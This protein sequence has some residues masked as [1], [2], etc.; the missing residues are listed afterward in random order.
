MKAD[1]DRIT[2]SSLSIACVS[3][4]HAR[5][6]ETPECDILI[7]SGDLT[8]HSSDKELEWFKNWIKAR[9]ARYKVFIAGNHDKKFQTHPYGSKDYV[10]ELCAKGDV[11]Y[12]EDTGCTVEGLT[13]WGSPWTPKFGESAFNL[14]GERDALE[15]WKKVPEGIDVLITHG[16]P[17]GILDTLANGKHVGDT[18]LIKAVARVKP[19]L[20]V[21]G[22]VHTGYGRTE[23]DGIVYVNAALCNEQ[24]WDY[25]VVNKPI[26]VDVKELRVRK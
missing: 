20:H 18:E 21:F 22:H 17:R 24:H 4:I 2:E 23:S 6:V 19:R 12:L 13:F 3:D 16:P 11:F 1:S 14:K 25:K 26:V 8:V 5:E 15:H 9:R 7:V 10:D